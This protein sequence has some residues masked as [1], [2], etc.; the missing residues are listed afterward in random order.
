MVTDDYDSTAAT[1]TDGA[2]LTGG[3]SGASGSD[4]KQPVGVSV[5][6][7]GIPSPLSPTKC[8]GETASSPTSGNEVGDLASLLACSFGR[9]A[10]VA[11]EDDASRMGSY[12]MLGHEMT[13]QAEPE[14]QPEKKTTSE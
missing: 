6:P 12:E 5:T 8:P 2:S 1:A 9:I 4:I 14:M 7:K 3:S 13:I 11:D 10:E